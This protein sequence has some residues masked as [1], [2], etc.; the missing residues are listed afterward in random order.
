MKAI[1]FS[2]PRNVEAVDIPDPQPGPQDVIVDV[3]YV[4]LCGSDLNAYRGFMPMVTYPRIPGHEV[5]GIVIAKGDQVPQTI[6]RDD[7]VMVSPYTSCNLCPA[8][9]AG[10][11]NCCQFNQTYGVQR[12]GVMTSRF[13]VH[14]AQVFSSQELS[15][16]E[17]ALVEPLSV[18][19]HAANRG[20]VTEMDTVLVIGCGTIGIG[21]IAAGVRKGATVIATDI[22]DAKLAEAQ[23][24]GAHYTIN[25]GQQNVL[26]VITELTREEGVDVAIEA[27]GLPETFRLAVDAVAFAGRVVYVGYAKQE[28]SYD[29][30]HFVRKELD[31]MGSRNALRVFPGVIKMMEKRQQP[32]EDLITRIY[33]FDEV[34]QALHDWDTAPG[35][36]T[37]ILIDLKV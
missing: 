23:K 25:S 20:R 4:G 30:T 19:Y 8:C 18:G 1:S 15:L 24:F 3:C 9:R 33:P 27:V 11:P 37:K 34:A 10:R 26:G 35:K 21:V 28:V 16:Q 6:N 31:I 17:L 29:T 5:S 7:R 13:A 2:A 22:D 12:D 14:Y 36:F 32:F